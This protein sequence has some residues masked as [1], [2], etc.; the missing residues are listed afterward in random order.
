MFPYVLEDSSILRADVRVPVPDDFTDAVDAV[1]DVE[2]VQQ[3]PGIR[4]IAYS[5]LFI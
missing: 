2:K 5:H 4:C 3:A 1:A